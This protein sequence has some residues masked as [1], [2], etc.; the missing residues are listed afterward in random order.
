MFPVPLMVS[1]LSA[2]RAQ[3]TLSPSAP[4]FPELITMSVH[5][6][7]TVVSALTVTDVPAP[8]TVV[9]LPTVHPANCFPAGAVNVQAGSV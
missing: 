4:Q 8:F 2:V 6:A 7:V 5:C 3:V 1:T 9:S